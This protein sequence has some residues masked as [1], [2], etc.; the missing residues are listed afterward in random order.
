V[1]DPP[2]PTEDEKEQPPERLHEE[3]AMS[4]VG[5]EDPERVREREGERDEPADE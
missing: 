5:H 4:G 2:E 1:Y 3:D